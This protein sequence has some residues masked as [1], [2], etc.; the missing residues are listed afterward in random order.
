MMKKGDVVKFVGDIDGYRVEYQRILKRDGIILCD[1]PYGYYKGKI[2][3]RW[4]AKTKRGTDQSHYHRPQE[5]RVVK[6][7]IPD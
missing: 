7:N 1:N 3:V 6:N 5:L 4:I 2:L